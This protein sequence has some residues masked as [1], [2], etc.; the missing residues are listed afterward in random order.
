[1]SSPLIPQGTL[2]RLRGS[3]TFSESPELNV[4]APF[5]GEEGINLNPEGPIVENLPTMTGT[6]TSPAPYQMITVEMELLKTQFL[7]NLFKRRLESNAVVGAITVRTDSSV[8][9]VYQ[10]QN[11]SIMAASPGSLNGRSVG[12][13]VAIQGFYLVNSSLFLAV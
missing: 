1:M 8:M 3:V 12:Y 5:L 2:N 11:C 10:I 13:R 7:A 6:V 9:G 4:T